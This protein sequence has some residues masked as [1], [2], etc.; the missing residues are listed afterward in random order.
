MNHTFSI[1]SNT[2]IDPRGGKMH[3]CVTMYYNEFLIYFV[4]LKLEIK[5]SI[6]T[7]LEF[8]DFPG[9]EIST[10]KFQ[11]FPGLSRVCTNPVNFK[12]NTTMTSK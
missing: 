7:A 3:T 5:I 8:Q 11:D 12:S 2:R 4:I 1:I 6:T 9:L 10:I